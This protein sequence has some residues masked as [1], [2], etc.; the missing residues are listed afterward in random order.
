MKTKMYKPLILAICA[1]A[2]STGSNAQLPNFVKVDTGAITILPGGHISSSCF[3]MDNDG[4]LDLII[5]NSAVYINRIFSVFKNE[6]NGLYIEIP[7]F[8]ADLD[9][10][11]PSSLGD[12]DNDGDVDLISG[13]PKKVLRIYPNDGYGNYQTYTTVYSPN[14]EYYPSLIDLN[15][16]GFLDL[17]AIDRWGSINYNNGNGG[18]LEHVSLGLLHDPPNIGMQGMSWGD[19]DDDGDMDFYGGYTYNGS[20]DSVSKNAC[21][22]NN[23]DGTFVKFDET[24]VIVDD[25]VSANPC[26]NWVDY[27]NDGDMDLYVVN[28]TLDS[29]N[30][31]LNAL[32]ENLGDM[33]FT[34]HV[35]EDEMY[36]NSFT[37]SSVHLS[38]VTWIMMGILIFM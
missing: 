20:V 21:F 5:G 26:I 35:F 31:P 24:S 13:L 12:I 8:I 15:T 34:K 37:N 10:K 17:V 9:Y 30:G 18:F 2:W 25:S 29:I 23:G 22:L 1:I 14:I 16:D 27:D 6:R 33:Q 36:R 32:Y 38:G 28:T 19:V 4:D 11:M 3:D 7:E